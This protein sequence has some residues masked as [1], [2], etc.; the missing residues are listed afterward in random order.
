LLDSALYG[1]PCIGWQKSEAQQILWPELTTENDADA[2]RLARILLTNSATLRSLAA[3][4]RAHCQKYYAPSEEDAAAWLRRLHS[5][6]SPYAMTG[7]R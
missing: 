4:G 5:A 6:K 2:V 3:R 1:V 7:T